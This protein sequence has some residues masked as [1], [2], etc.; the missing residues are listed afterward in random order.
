MKHLPLFFI[1]CVATFSPTHLYGKFGGLSAGA[2]VGGNISTLKGGNLKTD[3]NQWGGNAKL[4]LGIGKSVVDLIYVGVEA[5]GEYNFLPKS[6]MTNASRLESGVQ[7]AG[8]LR[9]GIHPTDNTLVYALYG[10][11][12]KTSKVKSLTAN[13]MSNSESGWSSI[14]GIG[15]EYALA[16]GAVIRLEGIYVPEQKFEMKDVQNLKFESDF[17]SVNIGVIVYL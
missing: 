9:A 17:I 10:V 2:S 1:L 7:I 16:L 13:F 11:Q 8:Y 3:L 15:F 6:E 5:F 12:T 4:Y 14:A